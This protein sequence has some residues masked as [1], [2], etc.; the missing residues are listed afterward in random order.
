MDWVCVV[1]STCHK[2]EEALSVALAGFAIAAKRAIQ[3]LNISVRKP[4][5]RSNVIRKREEAL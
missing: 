3:K 2:A 5:I 4:N 1:A